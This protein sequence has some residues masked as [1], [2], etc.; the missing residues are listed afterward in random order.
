[1]HGQHKCGPADASRPCRCPQVYV[2]SLEPADGDHAALECLP[3]K[4]NQ[5]SATACAVAGDYLVIAHSVHY[6]TYFSLMEKT[7]FCEYGHS[8]TIVKLFPDSCCCRV[9][10]LDNNDE[11]FLHNP[12]TGSCVRSVR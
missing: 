4:D 3:N 11:L 1:M 2:H 8:S 12:C 7:G 9:V 6:L 10:F 5:S